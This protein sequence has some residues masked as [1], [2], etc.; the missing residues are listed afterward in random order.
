MIVL[1]PS[2]RE[3]MGDV[4]RRWNA[5]GYS[6]SNRGM[7]LVVEPMRSNVVPMKRRSVASIFDFANRERT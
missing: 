5:L 6:V 1:L 4:V 2:P 3:S 7:R